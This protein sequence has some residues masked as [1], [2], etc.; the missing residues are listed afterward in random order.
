[1]KAYATGKR[2]E[3]KPIH[4]TVTIETETELAD[5][6]SLRTLDSEIGADE[7]DLDKVIHIISPM[8]EAVE[9]L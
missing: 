9:K 7:D 3:F 1:M 8:I 6:L 5:L 2:P 4:L